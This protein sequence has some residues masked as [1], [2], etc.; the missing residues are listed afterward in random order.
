MFRA[1]ARK[2]MET[3]VVPF[4]DEWEEA[5][6][7]S[8][9]VWKKA[10]AEGFLCTTLSDKYGGAGA[11][12]R[13]AAIF[14]EEQARV[15]ASGPGFTVHSDITATYL[16]HHA[17]ESIKQKWLPKMASGEAIGAIAM[18][19]PGTGSDLQAVTTTAV[20]DGDDYIINGA[21]AFISNGQ[22]C[23]IVIVVAKTDTSKGAHGTSLFL[24]EADREGFSRGQNVKKIGLK[25]QDTSELF[26]DDVRIPK[27][28]LIGSEGAGFIYLMTELPQ[29]RLVIAV[30]SIAGAVAAVEETITYTKERKAFGR[31]LTKFQN[32][33]FKLADALTEVQVGQVF[34]DRC[35]EL[36]AN[37]KLD[38]ATAA[39]AKLYATEMAGRVVD[40]CVQLF[41]G[42][43][44]CWEYPIARAYADVRVQRIF[45]GTSEIMRELIGRT[46][47]G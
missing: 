37:G 13:Y 45:G 28:N 1:A 19:E 8:R 24:V 10:G 16:E 31:P 22:L 30:S 6:V 5:G 7:V 40:E 18:T 32:T 42:Y 44:Y 46:L 21:K 14:L 34:V 2:F 41:G 36:H 11:D 39:M 3:E 47:V 35:I 20:P 17:T 4:H 12:F 9:D 23:D 25:A 29:E 15:R 43:G 27:E 33:R 38:V 26:F